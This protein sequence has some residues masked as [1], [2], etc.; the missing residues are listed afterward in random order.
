MESQTMSKEKLNLFRKCIDVICDL[1]A[2]SKTKK[3][4]SLTIDESTR[5]NVLMNQ[6]NHYKRTEFPGIDKLMTHVC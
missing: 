5:W 4:R 6:I 1:E 2:L 3:E